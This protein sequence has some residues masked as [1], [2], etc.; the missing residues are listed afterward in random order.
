MILETANLIYL[1]S[2]P[3]LTFIGVGFTLHLSLKKS[4]VTI[5][6]IE[7]RL[8]HLDECVD[9]L[10]NEMSIQYDRLSTRIDDVWKKLDEHDNRIFDLISNKEDKQ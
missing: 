6:R 3:L 8:D 4:A 1:I 10:R 5:T 2:I 7:S 9:R